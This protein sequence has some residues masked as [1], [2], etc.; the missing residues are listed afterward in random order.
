MSENA[1]T[2]AVE[3]TTSSKFK[4]DKS[5][6]TKIAAG[7]VIATGLILVVR[8]LKNKDDEGEISTTSTDAPAE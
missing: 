4:F 1:A 7:A 6:I 5:V 3:T 8:D 2:E